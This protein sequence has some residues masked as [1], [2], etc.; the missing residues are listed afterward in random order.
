MARNYSEESDVIGGNMATICLNMIVKNESA[1]IGKTLENLYQHFPLDYFVICDTGSTDNTVEIIRDFFIEKGIS[2]EIHQHEWKNFAHNRNLALSLCAGKSDYILIFDA[3]DYVEGKIPF[4]E[5]WDATAYFLNFKAQESAGV[6]LSRKVLLRNDGLHQWRGVVHEFLDYLG[7]EQTGILI[8]DY[9]I[10]A[11]S[12]GFRSLD[13]QKRALD[14]I[15]LL[16]KYYPTAEDLAPRYSFYLG[17][18]YL[19]L[20]D[21]DNAIK[22]YKQRFALYDEGKGW[23]QEA[24]YAGYQLAAI[25]MERNQFKEVVYYL[26]RCLEIDPERIEAWY[27]LAHYYLDLQYPAIAYYFAKNA[28]AHKTIPT[29]RIFLHSNLYLYFT[30][31]IFCLAA[32][33][34][35]RIEESYL[36]FKRVLENSP[37]GFIKEALVHHLSSYLSF[38]EAEPETEKTKLINQLTEQGLW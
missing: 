6:T 10:I 21:T 27:R 36:A 38:I 11:R 9:A 30:D 26:H 16:E 17:Q 35:G 12:A 31:Y 13:M 19:Y 3:D 25:Y 24:Y 7:E 23:N 20:K 22:W 28:L 34:T 37:S 32:F 4:P 29:G 14:D 18:S 2:G 15:A 5:K 1:I 33:R 8:G